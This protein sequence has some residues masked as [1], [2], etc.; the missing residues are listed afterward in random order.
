LVLHAE[1]M[2]LHFVNNQE[3]D[4]HMQM[5]MANVKEN[6]EEM[7]FH[8]TAILLNADSVVLGKEMVA[9][10]AISVDAVHTQMLEVPAGSVFDS[11]DTYL[12]KRHLLAHGQGSKVVGLEAVHPD[13]VLE[14]FPV[15]GVP[16]D[17]Q[18]D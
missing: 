4:A 6:G 11:V 9:T 8:Q 16:E 13:V 7:R 12:E 2:A 1:E 5:D 14:A 18:A 17:N 15:Y 3:K 10:E